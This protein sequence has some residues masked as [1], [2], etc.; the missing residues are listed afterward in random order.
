MVW[1]IG[2]KKLV[3]ERVLGSA[4]LTG[5]NNRVNHFTQQNIKHATLA[6]FADLQ[7]KLVFKHN[8]GFGYRSHNIECRWADILTVSSKQKGCACP[9]ISLSA[10]HPP[11]GVVSTIGGTEFTQGPYEGISG[12]FFNQF[13]T[14]NIGIVAQG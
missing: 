6:E 13:L 12:R 11:V 7:N 9:E 1:I 2:Q 8:Y 4:L 5:Q 14:R 10:L 3:G